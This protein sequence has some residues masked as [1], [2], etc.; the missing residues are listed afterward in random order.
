MNSEASDLNLVCYLLIK[1]INQPINQ[2]KVPKP[3]TKQETSSKQTGRRKKPTKKPPT[4]QAKIWNN[5][6]NLNLNSEFR[7]HCYSTAV[8]QSG[9]SGRCQPKNSLF[10]SHDNSNHPCL[11][12]WTSNSAFCC[13]LLTLPRVPVEGDGGTE[14]AMTSG[15]MSSRGGGV[16]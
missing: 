1:T 9:Y 16:I 3:N 2:Q 10:M 5:P 4:K 6:Q 14:R 15:I 7:N 8:I 11:P 12:D 13:F